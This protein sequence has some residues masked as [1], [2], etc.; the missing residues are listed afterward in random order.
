MAT[1]FKIV[2][3][4]EDK[5]TQYGSM[6]YP[7]EMTDSSGMKEKLNIFSKYPV[8]E[9]DVIHGEVY[10][11]GQYK[12]FKFVP[13]TAVVPQ[14][15]SGGPSMAEVKNAI[16]LGLIPQMQAE[17]K[18]IRELLT[19]IANGEKDIR[20]LLPKG[21]NYPKMTSENDGHGL[22]ELYEKKVSSEDSPF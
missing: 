6:L 4:G 10:M 5:P 13:K 21:D 20:Y 19:A 17:F 7:V 11:K 15:T 22:N 1:D 2:S 9:G 3:V 18:T 12:N 8:K 16:V 14:N